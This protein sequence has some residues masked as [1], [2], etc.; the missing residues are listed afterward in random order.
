[1][2]PIKISMTQSKGLHVYKKG[3]I[4]FENICKIIMEEYLKKQKKILEDIKKLE[5]L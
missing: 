5:L 1:M 3:C 4:N 2:S